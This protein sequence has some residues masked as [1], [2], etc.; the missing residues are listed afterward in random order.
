VKKEDFME[1]GITPVAYAGINFYNLEAEDR[2]VVARCVR[3]YS[4]LPEGALA[5]V[6]QLAYKILEEI[7]HLLGKSDWDKAQGA[8]TARTVESAPFCLTLI[9]SQKKLESI[10]ARTS[11]A[12]LSALIWANQTN[13]PVPEFITD[14]LNIEM[15]GAL[16]KSL[17]VQIPYAKLASDIIFAESVE[18]IALAIIQNIY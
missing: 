17:V 9:V 15:L 1:S 18:A 14:E 8:L 11:S 7:K 2:V 3:N 16:S 13:V 5:E 4:H 6:S 10:A 12:S